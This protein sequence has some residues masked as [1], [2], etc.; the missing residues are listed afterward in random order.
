ML[1][2]V[3][4][5]GNICSGKSSAVKFLTSM[6]NTYMINF[7]EIGHAVY[8]RNFIF[9]NLIKKLFSHNNPKI[10]SNIDTFQ[11]K[12]ERKELGKIIFD[13]NDVDKTLLKILNAQ[14]NPEMKN[15]FSLK[16]KEI[17]KKVSEEKTNSILFVEGAIII[18]SG[19]LK[20]FDE[21][22]LTVANRK[23]IEKRFLERMNSTP[24][25]NSSYDISILDEILKNQYN[26]EEKKK[27]CNEVIDTSGDYLD[28]Q[29]IY[30]NL[31]NKTIDNKIKI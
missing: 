22:W 9:L 30:L 20:L 4:V 14:I 28:T 5:T 7:D 13:K 11:E 12:F 3:A 24:D 17:E 26:V 15:L 10:F 1:Y 31:Y 2:K 19:S 29:K 25:K 18:E 27:V 8:K 6:P 16:V 21:I 23:E